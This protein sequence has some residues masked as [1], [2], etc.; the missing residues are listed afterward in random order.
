MFRLKVFQKYSTMNLDIFL[1]Y[2]EWGEVGNMKFNWTCQNF[3]A[4]MIC[5]ISWNR[6]ESCTSL[7]ISFFLSKL[8]LCI[9]VFSWTFTSWESTV[10][11]FRTRLD[12]SRF[13]ELVYELTFSKSGS[14]SFLVQMKWEIMVNWRVPGLLCWAEAA[15]WQKA[16]AFSW[17]IHL[18]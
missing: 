8:Q 2:L 18:R 11:S 16:W 9:E 13:L 4:E 7:L 3:E 10:T 14:N 17:L 5:L 12:L 6:S 1:D 15:G